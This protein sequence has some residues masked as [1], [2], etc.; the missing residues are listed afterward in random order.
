MS[1][2]KDSVKIVK[3][4]TKE[5]GAKKIQKLKQKVIKKSKKDIIKKNQK[6]LK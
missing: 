6:L 4:T 2:G 1:F 5:K 3:M